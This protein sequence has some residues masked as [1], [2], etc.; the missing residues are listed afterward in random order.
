MEKMHRAHY[1][2]STQ[3]FSAC[4]G[5]TTL[6]LSPVFTNLEP[7]NLNPLITRLISLATSPPS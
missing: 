4:S 6:P 1:M 2:E 5:G 7:P 3:S